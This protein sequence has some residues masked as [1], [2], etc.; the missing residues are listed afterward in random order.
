MQ[1]PLQGLRQRTQ[2]LVS[3]CTEAWAFQQ[4][5][6]AGGVLHLEQD[7]CNAL[8]AGVQRTCARGLLARPSREGRQA[9]NALL[10]RYTWQVAAGKAHTPVVGQYS[11]PQLE[12]LCAVA[13]ASP[14]GPV[15]CPTPSRSQLLRGP[16]PCDVM[17]PSH[18]PPGGAG[19]RT[20]TSRLLY[21]STSAGSAGG[22]FLLL[23]IALVGW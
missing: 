10:Q 3:F 18:R 23:H 20:V 13:L 22:H 4:R 6:D 19:K 21:L 11:S 5:Q 15:F 14:R 17:R 1:Q 2:Q 9:V 8:K 16:T 7:S 12:L